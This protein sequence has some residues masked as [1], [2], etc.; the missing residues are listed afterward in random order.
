MTTQR[1]QTSPEALLTL[2]RALYVVF[3]LPCFI[4][5]TVASFLMAGGSSGQDRTETLMF[6][7]LMSLGVIIPVTIFILKALGNRRLLKNIVQELSDSDKFSPDASFEVYKEGEGKYFGIDSNNGTILYIRLIRKG[8]VEV[9]GLAM[10]DWTSRELE[11][12]KLRLYTKFPELPCIEIA[13][14]WAQRW[15]DSLGAM[16][17]KRYAMTKPFGQYVSEHVEALERQNNI[18][19]LKLA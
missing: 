12:K 10:G 8:Q 15:Y 14:P 11:G 2:L 16:E 6:G 9:V 4:F 18:H 17:Y 7:A 19:I 1:L 3:G 5:L 13:V